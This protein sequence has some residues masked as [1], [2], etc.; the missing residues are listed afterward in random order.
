[1]NAQQ[2]LNTIRARKPL[3]HHLANYVVMNE[4]AS[5]TMSVVS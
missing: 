1:M 3:V 5:F 2:T 4:T